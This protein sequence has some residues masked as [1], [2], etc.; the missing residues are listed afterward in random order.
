MSFVDLTF[1]KGF[2]SAEEMKGFIKVGTNGSFTQLKELPADVEPDIDFSKIY[3]LAQIQFKATIRR[4]A[5]SITPTFSSLVLKVY[6]Y[7]NIIDIVLV[8]ENEMLDKPK[9][10]EEFEFLGATT[11]GRIEFPDEMNYFFYLLANLD[12]KEEIY[13]LQGRPTKDIITTENIASAGLVYVAQKLLENNKDFIHSL[14]PT[15]E[16]FLPLIYCAGS[17]E[18]FNKS[19]IP[20]L[21]LNESLFS[22]YYPVTAEQR[23]HFSEVI[24][25]LNNLESSI[26]VPL[27]LNLIVRLYADEPIVLKSTNLTLENDP[28]FAVPA[29]KTIELFKVATPF[30]Y[31]QEFLKA[32]LI[33]EAILFIEAGGFDYS[34]DNSIVM[35]FLE[36]LKL[37]GFQNPFIF[38]DGVVTSVNGED[39]H[40][41]D[42][43]LSN[44]KKYTLEPTK[45]Y[46]I[47]Y[48]DF[49]K[50]IIYAALG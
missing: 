34:I 27:Y 46:D 44:P 24:E 19:F 38:I 35:E 8:T 47:K 11:L 30:E 41:G 13:S 21:T 45:Y 33:N 15:T 14:L 20:L 22:K 18:N 4:I 42:L 23:S 10:F 50:E 25:Y 31:L 40:L 7:S 5:N 49:T 1:E 6:P 3:D 17:T 16:E 36:G 9:F 29:G 37:D 32:D 48:N 12:S 43:V 39:I 2:R 28:D 26:K